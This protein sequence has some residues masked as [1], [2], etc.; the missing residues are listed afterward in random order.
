M[1]DWMALITAMLIIATI[2]Y[3]YYL[4]SYRK[5]KVGQYERIYRFIL[6]ILF[7]VFFISVFLSLQ[8]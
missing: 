4:R 5:E 8:K 2:T 3:R 1:S 7:I 6:P